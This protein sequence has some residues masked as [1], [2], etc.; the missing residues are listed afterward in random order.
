[1]HACP[2]LATCYGWLIIF[3][4]ALFL[5]ADYC[6]SEAT[7]PWAG[8]CICN[9][10]FVSFLFLFL[11]LLFQA[12]YHSLSPLLGEKHWVSVRPDFLC[13]S[14]GVAEGIYIKNIT[15]QYVG[16]AGA[17]E[18]LRGVHRICDW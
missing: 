18:I 16:T 2:N 14:Q 5:M 13:L 12:A 4:G 17:V 10:V 11:L 8:K 1:M 15:I 9:C 6:Q 7:L 3:D